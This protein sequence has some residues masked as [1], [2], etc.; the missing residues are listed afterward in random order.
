MSTRDELKRAY[1][2]QPPAMGVFLVR[3]L[4][5]N[6]FVAGASRNVEGSLNRYRFMLQ[7]GKPGDPFLKYPDLMTDYKTLGADAFEFAVLDTLKP[8]TEPGWD[9]T[10]DLNQLEAMWMETLRGRAWTPYGRS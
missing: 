3:N 8:K 5:T 7:M 4:R 6:R 9:A 2:E 1:K 10:D